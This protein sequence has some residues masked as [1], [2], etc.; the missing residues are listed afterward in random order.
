MQA[1]S[2]LV[3]GAH[4]AGTSLITRSLQTLG[5]ELGDHLMEP[6]QGNAK[7]YFED[8]RVVELN[9]RLLAKANARWSDIGPLES[10]LL[11]AGHVDEEQAEARAIIKSFKGPVF[12]LK[13]P[14]L[15]ILAP[16]WLEALAACGAE[17]AILICLRHPGDVARSLNRRDLTPLE[18]GAFIWLRYMMAAM[19]A[20]D[21]CKAIVTSYD[22]MVDNPEAEIRRLARALELDPPEDFASQLALFTDEFVEK[23]LRHHDTQDLPGA[24]RAVMDMYRLLDG[25]ASVEDGVPAALLGE[26]A[27]I[28]AWL[29]DLAGL[30]RFSDAVERMFTNTSAKYEALKR[31][32]SGP[33]QA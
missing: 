1:R 29:D 21:A 18:K 26:I 13:D 20:A 9:E 33:G 28:S 25:A 27:H 16:F 11:A 17:P 30:R 6:A 7:G 14:R 22:R 19:T 5:L 12:A 8:M 15:S 10:D 32:R 23:G 3:L 2:V 24:P 31:D 4:R